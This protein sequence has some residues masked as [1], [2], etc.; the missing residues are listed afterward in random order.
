MNTQ[1]SLAEYG[2]ICFGF[3][4]LCQTIGFGEI[5]WDNIALTHR[6]EQKLNQNKLNLQLWIS[7]IPEV[8]LNEVSTIL[9]NLHLHEFLGRKICESTRI[10][11]IQELQ[12]CIYNA[13][14]TNQLYRK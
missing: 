1:E 2:T 9:D 5:I 7:S 3:E 14:A 12:R 13:I 4:W 6:L 11:F 8:Y 10:A